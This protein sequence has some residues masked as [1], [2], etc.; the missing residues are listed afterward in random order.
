MDNETKIEW[1]QFKDTKSD[2][3]RKGEQTLCHGYYTFWYGL[4]DGCQKI[5]EE[6]VEM[7]PLV[8]DHYAAYLMFSI[9]SRKLD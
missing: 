2:L 6:E 5:V 9:C 1:V 3:Q 4:L 8:T 7:I